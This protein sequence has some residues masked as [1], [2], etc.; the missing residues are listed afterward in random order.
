M[1]LKN[2]QFAPHKLSHTWK[3]PLLN[4]NVDRN[5]LLVLISDTGLEPC[6]LCPRNFFQPFN[7]RTNCYECPSGNRT[8]NE[9]SVDHTSC[10]AIECTDNICQ[11]GGLCLARHHQIQCYCPAGFSGKFC[12]VNI[13]ECDSTPCYNGG[14]CVDL[15]QSYRCECLDGYSGLQCQIEESDCVPGACP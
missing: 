12:E 14:K 15:P 8:I 1:D 3:P 6:N 5:V 13:N 7:G 9:G 2:V 4:N 11:N 10:Q